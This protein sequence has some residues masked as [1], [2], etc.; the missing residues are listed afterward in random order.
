MHPTIERFQS[1]YSDLLQSTQ[2]LNSKLPALYSDNIT[3][4]DP[5]H[6]L[7]GLEDLGAYLQS[8]CMDLLSCS[9]EVEQVS[10]MEEE[11]YIH[12]HMHYQHPKLSGGRISTIV[13]I[14]HIKFD[15]KVYYHRDYFDLGEMVYEKL[16]L[17]G[18]VIRY[19]K[20]R[21]RQ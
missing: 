3:F 19:L 20:N 8:N 18:A 14:S 9:F 2:N 4:I 15:E 11:A 1:F 16:P 10:Q 6:S 21:I 7:Q 13:G 5:A 12:W 17:I